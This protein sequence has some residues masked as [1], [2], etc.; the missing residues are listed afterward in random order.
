MCWWAQCV[1]EGP[2]NASFNM[3][4]NVCLSGSDLTVPIALIPQCMPSDGSSGNVD[5]REEGV[6][7][8]RQGYLLCCGLVSWIMAVVEFLFGCMGAAPSHVRHMM[9]RFDVAADSAVQRTNA[10]LSQL[11]V[12]DMVACATGA[13]LVLSLLTDGL[14]AHR[15]ALMDVFIV[16]VGL[17]LVYQSCCSATVDVNGTLDGAWTTVDGAELEAECC[18]GPAPMDADEPSEPDTI[19]SGAGDDL[20][21]KTSANGV[22]ARD[23][24]AGCALGAGLGCQLPGEPMEPL[25]MAEA[26]LEDAADLCTCGTRIDIM[27][28]AAVCQAGATVNGAVMDQVGAAVCQAG[29]TVNGAAVDKVGAAVCSDSTIARRIELL[30]S[31]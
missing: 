22:V 18:C 21:T 3:D 11:S 28:V 15:I 12:L 31:T 4:G 10:G 27:E 23:V 19:V 29:A 8:W 16:V 26:V 9:W 17:P 5:S 6:E 13:L 20:S 30:N 24:V 1:P 2:G 14:S 25:E 7:A